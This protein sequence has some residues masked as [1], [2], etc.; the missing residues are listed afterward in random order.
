MLEFIIKYINN[1]G[2]LVFFKDLPKTTKTS[3][4]C[5]HL[6]Q[7]SMS[8]DIYLFYLFIFP[9]FAFIDLL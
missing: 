2:R 1:D 4:V 9:F 7:L 3:G 5:V 8:P 6:A